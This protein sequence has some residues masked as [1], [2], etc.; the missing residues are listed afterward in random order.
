LAEFEDQAL[1]DEFLIEMDDEALAEELA[2]TAAIRAG[3]CAYRYIDDHCEPVY[4]RA[5]R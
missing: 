4:R 5:F 2:A 3:S 1:S